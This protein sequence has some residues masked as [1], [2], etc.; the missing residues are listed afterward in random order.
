MFDDN[1]K[2]SFQ[3]SRGGGIALSAIG[4]SM[5]G[6]VSAVF[7]RSFYMALGDDWVCV[8]SEDMPMGPLNIRSSAPAGTHWPSSELKLDDRVLIAAGSAH[9]GS[10]FVFSLADALAWKAVLPLGWTARSLQAGLGHL[11]NL[12]PHYGDSDGLAA[13]T[14]RYPVPRTVNATADAARDSITRLATALEYDEFRTGVIAKAATGLIGL[15]PGLTPSGDDFLGGMMIALHTIDREEAAT[16]LWT[17]IAPRVSIRTGA[18]SAAHLRAAATG[19]GHEAGHA[20]LSSLL[21]GESDSLRNTLDRIDAIG[22]SSGW[23]MLAGM[24]TVLRAI[25]DRD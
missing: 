19:M 6:Q 18:I 5:I 24:L 13:F 11:D 23:D 16:S 20:I 2:T 4:R 14:R 9:V 21:R 7:D 8:G 25:Y 22:H 3:V 15:G 10:Q 17:A 1:V 12:L